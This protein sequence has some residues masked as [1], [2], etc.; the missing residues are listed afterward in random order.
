MLLVQLPDRVERIALNPIVHPLGIGKIQNRIT[1]AAEHYSVINS[2]KKTRTPVRSAT[3]RSLA[4]GTKNHKTRQ[5]LRFRSQPVKS[6]RANART[7]K[8]LRPRMHHNLRRGVIERIRVHR[9]HDGNVIRHFT[10]LRQQLRKLSPTLSVFGKL[11]FRPEEFRLR[12]DERRAV[13]L[14]Q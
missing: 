2:R 1:L 4:S 11:K 3:A 6:P 14:K 12:I 9:F 5:I 7:P 13:I 8:L 10:E